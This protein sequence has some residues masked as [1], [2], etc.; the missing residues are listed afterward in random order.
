MTRHDDAV[1]IG[2]DSRRAHRGAQYPYRK[3]LNN[4]YRINRLS[5]PSRRST[6]HAAPISVTF[7]LIVDGP[8]ASSMHTL[9]SVAYGLKSLIELA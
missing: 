5:Q 4:D 7:I 2:G 9:S 3:P 8:Y 1:S 6:I